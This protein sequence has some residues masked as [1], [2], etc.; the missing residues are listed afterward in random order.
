MMSTSAG[1]RDPWCGYLCS[2]GRKEGKHSV[3]FRLLS[4]ANTTRDTMG[5]QSGTKVKEEPTSEMK[6]YG[7][8]TPVCPVQGE[9]LALHGLRWIH[10]V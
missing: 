8:L 3:V 9:W 7:V 5:V 1:E 6:T 2:I 4:A 10:R